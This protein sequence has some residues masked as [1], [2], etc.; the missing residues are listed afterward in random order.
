[1]T[2]YLDIHTLRDSLRYRRSEWALAA[3][4]A[5]GWGFV[6]LLPANTFD[7]SIAYSAM[8]DWAR[9]ETWGRTCIA[10]GSARLMVLYING[11]WRR[12]SHARMVLAGL[13]AFVW[14]TVT[15]GL[16]RAGATVP[17]LVIYPIFFI[18][19]LHTVYEAGSDARVADEKHRVHDT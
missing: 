4:L 12:C 17:G 10:I 6:L 2:V 13:S 5:L 1:M 3:I 19:E 9:E 18:M 11:R 14:F 15:L 7:G 16:I 8:A